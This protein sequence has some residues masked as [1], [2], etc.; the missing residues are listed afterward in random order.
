M[1]KD[2]WIG[3]R[4]R[5]NFCYTQ[6]QIPSYSPDCKNSLIISDLDKG[7]IQGISDHALIV[8]NG[9]KYLIPIEKIKDILSIVQEIIG[10]KKVI[11]QKP[12]SI[13]ERE[14]LN[15]L[16]EDFIRHNIFEKYG[17]LIDSIKEIETK[18]GD[19][20]VYELSSDKGKFILK[21]YG[22]DLNLFNAQTS[23][24]KDNPF[25]P[26]VIASKDQTLPIIFGDSIYYL[27]EFLG[28]T[29]FSEDRN[30][31]YSL[32]GKHMALIHNEFNK[33]SSL[34]KGLEK[35][36]IQQGN[37]L[38]E[39]NLISMKIDL[40]E[41]FQRYFSTEDISSFFENI[42]DFQ[43]SLPS[44][45]IHGDL[46]KSNLIWNGNDAKAIDFEMINF[47]RRINEFIPALL[48]EGNLSIPKYDSE[49]LSQILE[50]YNSHSNKRLTNEEITVL[51]DILKISL[52]KSY[53]IYVM[54][55]NLN[56]PDFKNQIKNSLN[57]LGGET[58]VH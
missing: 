28:G 48:L 22:K 21:Y 35:H 42:Q 55:R 32:I 6:G 1:Q 5:D 56:N 57:T 26:K 52:I 44:Q 20:R 33:K 58:N 45:I 12:N 36:L 39:S 17:F 47:S 9:K 50:G 41:N 11:Y 53:A 15:N 2:N 3:L 38:S 7:N 24:L 51:P 4:E 46:N 43:N 8:E 27:E 34:I 18:K 29:S 23:L 40:G 30:S 31:L 54:R 14:S 13:L 49:S 25:F 37:P 16:E 19:H 10:E